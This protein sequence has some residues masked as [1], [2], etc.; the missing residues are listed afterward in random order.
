MGEGMY[1]RTTRRGHGGGRAAATVLVVAAVAL[2][3]AGCGDSDGGGSGG[4]SGRN[5]GQHEPTSLPVDSKPRSVTWS[6]GMGKHTRHDLRVAPKLARGTPSDL[7]HMRLDKDLK[8]K[9]PYY[10]TVSYTNTGEETVR[11]PA[12][13]DDFSVVDTEGDEG[14]SVMTFGGWGS[15]GSGLPPACRAES[16]DK[17]KA[18]GKAKACEI[19]MM[20]KGRQPA[21]I[22][23]ANGDYDPQSTPYVWKVGG[24]R[25]AAAKGP[26]EAAESAWKNAGKESTPVRV[27]PKSVRKGKISDLRRFSLEK[28]DKNAVPYYVTL[29]YR[30]GSGQK[31]YPD[32]QDGVR[33]GTDTGRRISKLDLLDVSGQ[34]PVAGC[35]EAKPYGMVKPKA[36]VVQCSVHLVPKGDKPATVEF[37]GKGGGARHLTWKAK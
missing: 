8:G 35:P 21:S 29:E 6:S 31:L 17:L 23:Y 16:P 27:T 18:G 24:R 30:N 26:H 32:M 11:D 12:P 33:L 10:L 15:S 19:V 7:K 20:S 28:D 3:A 22:S 37:A 5:S 13:E 4:G 9:V 1:N 14:H 34:D 25:D 36:T 2:T